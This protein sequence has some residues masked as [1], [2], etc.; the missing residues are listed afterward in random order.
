[1][2]KDDARA[3][4][5]STQLLRIHWSSVIT[6]HLGYAIVTNVAVWS[7]FAKV[8]VDSSLGQPLFIGVAA[9][10]SSFM[11]GLWR[12]Y[13]RHIDNHI[14]QLYPEL[15]FYEGL[16]GVPSEYSTSRYLMKAVGRVDRILS[17]PDEGLTRDKKREGI[18]KLVESKHIGRRAHKWLDHGVLLAIV[19]MF[20]G[21]FSAF[22]YAGEWWTIGNL[23]CSLVII[24]GFGITLFEYCYYQKDPN[25]ALIEKTLEEV[26]S[27]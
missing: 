20:A 25:E 26:R 12:L 10:I 11:L 5:Q 27:G 2:E 24:V 1:M 7:Y 18:T 6:T 4:L 21:S 3:L 16:L 8:Y 19:V 15:L 23:V 13:T 17:L 14:A 9:A 22:H